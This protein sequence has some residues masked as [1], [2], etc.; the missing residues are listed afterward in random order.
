MGYQLTLRI[1]APAAHLR[2]LRVGE[3]HVV[4]MR[5]IIDQRGAGRVLLALGELFDLLQGLLQKPGHCSNV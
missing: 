4:A 1:G 2:E 3:A 5:E